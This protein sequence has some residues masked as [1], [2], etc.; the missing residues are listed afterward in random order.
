M[1]GRLSSSVC[2][3]QLLSQE[4]PA[5][6][7]IVQKTGDRVSMKA[8]MS[9]LLCR[10][11]RIGD[12]Q[13]R[14]V[15]QHSEF[16]HQAGT[17]RA[18]LLTPA[19]VLA[20]HPQH[21]SSPCSASLLLLM[22]RFLR[23]LLQQAIQLLAGYTSQECETCAHGKVCGAARWTPSLCLSQRRSVRSGAKRARASAPGTW[24]AP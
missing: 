11:L 23:L 19:A 3:C 9:H 21:L 7:S 14:R 4:L 24:L 20:C 6:A 12:R 8:L 17:A 15:S 5:G 18:M 13:A 1:E 16:S 10:L 2:A 22:T